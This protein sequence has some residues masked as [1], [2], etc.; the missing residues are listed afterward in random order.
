[1][2]DGPFG[3]REAQ[4][5]E[6]VHRPAERL[7]TLRKAGR[8]ITCELRR[9]GEFEWETQLLRDG[10]FYTGGRFNLKQPAVAHADVLRRD[11]EAEGWTG[12]DM[13]RLCAAGG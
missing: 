9:H 6:R 5:T 8:Q 13:H 11:L 7:W 2:T 3:T 1:M 12:N 10:E 4:I